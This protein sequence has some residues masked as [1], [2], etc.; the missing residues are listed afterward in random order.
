MCVCVCGC[1]CACV[2][3]C[4]RACVCVGVCVCRCVSICV[5]VAS[6]IVK[7]PVPP[8]YVE[9]ERCKY[10][11]YILYYYDNDDRIL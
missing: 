10:V 5:N 3:A 11:L 4:V 1:V 6:A 7:L 9:D 2:R 8:L